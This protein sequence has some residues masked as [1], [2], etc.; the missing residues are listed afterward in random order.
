[1]ADVVLPYTNCDAQQHV[2]LHLQCTCMN[3]YYVMYPCTWQSR[4]R[5]GMMGGTGRL[6]GGFGSWL[7]HDVITLLND[8]HSCIKILWSLK[9]SRGLLRND[10]IIAS[11]LFPVIFISV[12]TSSTFLPVTSRSYGDHYQFKALCCIHATM[13]YICSQHANIYDTYSMSLS[14]ITDD[15]MNVDAILNSK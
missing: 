15:I 2:H 5:G 1:M 4:Y 9:W 10:D 3:I 6:R 12:R 8:H 7:V 14:V 13:V 11:A